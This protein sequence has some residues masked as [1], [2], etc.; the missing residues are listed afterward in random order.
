MEKCIVL[1][2]S[3]LISGFQPQLVDQKC[4]TVPEIIEEIKDGQAKLVAELCLGERSVNLLQPSEETVN[5]VRSF[6]ESTGEIGLLSEPDI[7]LISLALEFKRKGRVPVI[8]TDDYDIQNVAARLGIE[9]SPLA[10]RGIKEVFEWRNV[11]VGC[12][13]DFPPETTGKCNVCG[14]RLR[15]KVTKKT[16]LE[17]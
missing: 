4:Y 3:A 1:D 15:K 16:S 2:A 10:E 17:D 8:V 9:Y 11:C 5:E 7:K 12:G 14:S 13:R 6:S